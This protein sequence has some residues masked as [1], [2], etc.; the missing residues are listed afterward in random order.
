VITV[1]QVWELA[2]TVAPRFRLLVVLA[3]FMGLRR[4]ELFGLRRTS[5]NLLYRT[6]TVKE[7]R[8]QLKDGRVIAG[9]PKTVAGQRTIV[10]P[11]PLILEIEAHIAAFAQPQPDG[12]LFVVNEE[13]P[14]ETTCGSTSGP[15]PDRSSGWPTCT[16][17]ICATSRTLSRRR[18]VPAPAS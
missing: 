11:E 3:A 5:V 9:P 6:L 13:A 1:A 10:I 16:S 18:P 4:G 8:Q 15:V 17:T 12:L 2:E 7:Q 14:C